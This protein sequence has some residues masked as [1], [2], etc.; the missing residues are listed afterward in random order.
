MFLPSATTRTRTSVQYLPGPRDYQGGLK[1][2]GRR[3]RTTISASGLAFY[4][5]LLRSAHALRFLPPTA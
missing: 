2:V 1:I 3:S 4:E 5:L